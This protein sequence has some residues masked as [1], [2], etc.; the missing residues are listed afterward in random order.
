MMHKYIRCLTGNDD[1]LRR[2]LDYL[3]AEGLTG[4]T[5]VI[6]T[7]DQ[8]YWLG[9]HGLYDKRLILETS[10]RMP[11]LVRY[12]RRIKAGSVNRDLCMNVDIAPTLLEL[13][14]VAVPVA[15]QGRSMMPLLKGKQVADWRTA[16]FYTYWS[17]PAH[18]GIRTGRFTYLKV[19]GHPDELFDR[20]KDPDQR[21]NVA[22]REAYREVIKE[23]ELELNRQIRE[24]GISASELPGARKK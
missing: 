22:G 21:Y 18:Y 3:D 6:Y 5:V 16:Q 13:A 11:F 10:M 15:M 23:L 19:T 2:V 4:D 12:P 24:A 17:N 8:G 14:G 20:Q 7:S 1:N 9:Q